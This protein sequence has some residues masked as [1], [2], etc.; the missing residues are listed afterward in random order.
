PKIKWIKDNEPKVWKKTKS[1]LDPRGYIV[2][3]LTDKK[4]IDHYTAFH[5]GYGYS[6]SEYNWNKRDFE[7]AEID[8]SIM[9]EVKWSHEVA[10]YINSE[11]A[12]KTGLLE[13]T[14]VITGTGDALAEMLSSGVY[15]T[16][17]TVLLYG[18]TMPI[19][20]I[21]DNY[22]TNKSKYLKAPSWTKSK[23]I[24]SSGI[25]SGM[26]SFSWFKNLTGYKTTEELFLQTRKLETI[27]AS[28]E[29][30]FSFPYFTSQIDPKNDLQRRASFLGLSHHHELQH[31]FKALIEGIGFSLR[32]SMEDSPEITVIKAIGGG[33]QNSFLLQTISDI[34]NIEQHTIL[35]KDRK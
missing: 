7:I 14:P 21:S 26:S 27:K 23:S 1:I 35:K 17:D 6:L 3:K 5:S 29:G 8:I 19:M 22:S 16:K 9:P 25:R 30:L 32:L 11:S 34:C 18:S 10:G 15:K 2:F 28:E 20:T 33:S 4:V 13:G 31:L 12:K 24:I